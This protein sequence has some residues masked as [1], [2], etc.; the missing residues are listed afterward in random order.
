MASGPGA[1][2]LVSSGLVAF[3]AQWRTIGRA[4]AGMLPN[5]ILRTPTAD[6]PS[7][8]TGPLQRA[9]VRPEDIEVP[10]SWFLGGLVVSATGIISI[11]HLYFEIPVHYGTP[12]RWR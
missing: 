7:A 1:P 4:L 11:A 10:T 12:S 6:R 5:K 3:A 2:L 8:P 9:K